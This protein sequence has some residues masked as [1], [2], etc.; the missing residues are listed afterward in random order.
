MDVLTFIANIINSLVWPSV[1]ISIAWMIHGP[2]G[3]LLVALKNR[4]IEITFKRWRIS[5]KNELTELSH[6]L[7]SSTS[8]DIVLAQKKINNMLK[9]MEEDAELYGNILKSPSKEIQKP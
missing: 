4:N 6:C 2:V 1:A 5:F 9:Q 7:D 3:D 8:E